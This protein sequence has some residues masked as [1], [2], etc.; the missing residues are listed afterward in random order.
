MGF[1]GLHPLLDGGAKSERQ[2]RAAV[3]AGLGE[4][5]GSCAQPP[6]TA[7]DAQGEA[8]SGGAAAPQGALGVM[9]PQAMGHTGG[10]GQ[11]AADFSSSS[12]GASGTPTA[13]SVAASA[14]RAVIGSLLRPRG[15]PAKPNWCL[16]PLPWIP[17]QTPGSLL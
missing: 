12:S 14:A 16:R 17:P 11:A 8:R 2:A 10:V 5:A 13:L 7:G 9:L 6:G 1:W 4:N 15:S 3:P